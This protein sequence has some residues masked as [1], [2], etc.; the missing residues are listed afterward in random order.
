MTRE[1]NFEVEK[2]KADE[3]IASLQRVVHGIDKEK[4]LYFYTF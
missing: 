1:S 4:K 3:E 2:R